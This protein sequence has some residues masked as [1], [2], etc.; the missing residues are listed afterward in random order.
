LT[1]GDGFTETTS[2]NEP[3]ARLGEGGTRKKDQS[4]AIIPDA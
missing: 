2:K 3:M 1:V 4:E